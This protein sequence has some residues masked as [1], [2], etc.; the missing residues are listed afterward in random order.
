MKTLRTFPAIAVAVNMLATGLLAI[1]STS[2]AAP[3]NLSDNPL[4]ASQSAPPLTLMTM[5]RDHKLYYEA[6]NDA[7]DLNGDGV[8]DTT[9][10][11][12]II[13]YYGYFG[14]NICYVYAVGNNRFE[15]SS[16][17]TDK[18]CSGSSEW[19]GDFLNY[20][21]TS[22]IDAL[23][24]V[25]YGGT[26]SVDTSS[27]TVLERSYIPQDA[28]SWGKEYTDIATN[29]FDIREY[30]SLNLPVSGHRH[31]FANTTLVSENDAPLLRV[32][33]DSDFRVWEWLSKERPVAGNSCINGGT[34]CEQGASRITDYVVR[35]RVCV[36]GRLEANCQAYPNGTA[37]L[38]ACC[39]AM[40]KTTACTSVCS[41][42]PMRKIPLAAYCVKMSVLLLTKSMPM[43]APIPR[44]LA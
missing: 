18:R 30:S 39:K 27:E 15:P 7:S 28:H 23:R 2:Q 5:G 44:L 17:T 38:S 22:R 3:L 37:N 14:S 12:D 24:K 20:L 31:L 19:S 32:L 9:Y 33:N 16:A 42:A 36:S 41:L 10:K 35:V 29:G 43:T 34:S 26:R 4:F 8:L 13:D 25:F 21:T 6:Y 40:A 1:V 11:P